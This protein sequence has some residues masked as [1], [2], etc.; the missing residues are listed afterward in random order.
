M[1][2]LSQGQYSLELYLVHFPHHILAGQPQVDASGIDVPM[3]KLFLEGVKPPTAVEEV[4]S[5]AVAEEV[6]VHAAPEVS[7]PRRVLDDLIGPLLR[8]VTALAGWEQK[9]VTI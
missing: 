5:V 8:D 7:S 3:A 4:D 2:Q 9:I 1:N 6:G